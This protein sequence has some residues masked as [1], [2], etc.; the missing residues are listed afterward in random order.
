MVAGSI[1]K[2]RFRMFLISA[3]A[4]LALILALV[5]VYGVMSFV[6]TQRTSEF[7]L[8]VA[9]GANPADVVGL[10]LRGALRLAVIGLTIG[11]LLSLAASRVMAS[12]LFALKPTDAV[13]YAA[14]LLAVIPIILLAAAVPA[15]RAARIDPVTA[16]RQ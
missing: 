3:F 1:S 15:W 9:M 13:T 7:G 14:V 4:G 10:V 2:P 6:I 12:M 11:L 8:R 5:G 16:L